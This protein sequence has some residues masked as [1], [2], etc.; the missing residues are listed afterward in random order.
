[1][2]GRCPSVGDCQ[3]RGVGGGGFVSSRKGWHRGFSEWKPGKGITFEMQIKK[4]SN[5]YQRRNY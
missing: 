1:V 5:K 3:D 4:L 2:N